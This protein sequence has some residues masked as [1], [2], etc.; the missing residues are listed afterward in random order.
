[1]ASPEQFTMQEDKFWPL[2]EVGL[3]AHLWI[4]E[5]KKW[6]YARQGGTFLTASGSIAN[7]PRL[8]QDY[9]QGKARHV[10]VDLMASSCGRENWL[11]NHDDH[12]RR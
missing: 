1:M 8:D 2:R 9:I 11:R 5:R 4:Q 6:V 3:E 7:W 10:L 12:A